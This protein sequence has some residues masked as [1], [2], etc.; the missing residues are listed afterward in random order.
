M[1]HAAPGTITI[2]NWK[3]FQNYKFRNPPWI[4]VYGDLLDAEQCPWYRGLSDSAARFLLE[5][6]LLARRDKGVVPFDTLMILRDLKRPTSDKSLLDDA[7]IELASATAIT[8][9]GTDASAAFLAT[10]AHRVSESQSFR[11][12]DTSYPATP[13]NLKSRFVLHVQQ[14]DGCWLWTGSVRGGYGAFNVDGRTEAAHRVAW[15]LEF[16]AW[17]SR[18]LMHSCHTKLC[19]R[20]SH[21]A[22]G[23][24]SANALASINAGVT[25]GAMKLTREQVTVIRS[26]SEAGESLVA[27]AAA[28]AVA[29]STIQRIVSGEA[30]PEAV[31]GQ[32]QQPNDQGGVPR[33][34]P[35]PFAV[36]F[37]LIRA[38]LWRPDGQCPAEI[39]GKPWSEG[40]EGT[41]IR[42][43][44]KSY[45][46]SDLEVVVM[47][48][49]NMLRGLTESERPG[50]L[51]IGAKASL[52]AVF[53]TRSGVVQMVEHCRR[54][55]WTVENRRPKKSRA[56][57]PTAVSALL[58]GVLP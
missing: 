34:T 14:T 21:L 38:H 10:L 33:E 56:S 28:F 25:M 55:Y 16:G 8:I 35:N 29:K 4:R 18:M 27:L 31:T 13:S 23:D 40:Q 2:K 39:A 26:R 44:L 7:L 53:H 41:V 54:A 17:P 12:S 48:L 3:R 9:A 52:R 43:L 47:G 1:K 42:D 46:L 24:K 22:E 6:W 11:V 50:W 51:A 19:V 36:L 57:E 30:W 58:P 45:S 5:L 49:G 37:G 32:E 15:L 20:I